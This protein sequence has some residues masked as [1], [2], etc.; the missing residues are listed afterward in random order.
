MERRATDVPF[1]GPIQSMRTEGVLAGG[2][3][4]WA[5]SYHSTYLAPRFKKS[6]ANV[7]SCTAQK[8][9]SQV[10]HSGTKR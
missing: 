2:K 7:P 6:A 9:P 8:L 3:A 10:Q 4:V 5:F 1:P